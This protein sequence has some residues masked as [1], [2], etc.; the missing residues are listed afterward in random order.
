MARWQPQGNNDA[1]AS[2]LQPRYRRLLSVGALLDES[3]QLFRQHWITLALFGLAALVPSWLVLLILYTGGF[4]QRVLLGSLD[5][6]ASFPIAAL[7]MVMGLGLLSGL[8]TVLWTAASTAAANAF[9]HGRRPSVVG[10]YVHALKRFPA[11]LGATVVYVLIAL[12]LTIA[13]GVLFV[14]TGLGTI[15]TL[16]AVVGLIYWWRQRAGR[17]PWLKWLIILTAPFGLVTYYSLRWALWL[18]ALVIE[19]EGP[20]GSL[21][22]SHRLTEHE[23]FRVFS[24]LSLV[25]VIVLV[26]VSVPVTIVDI[27]FGVFARPGNTAYQEALQV[28][29]STV[30][31]LCQVLFS[32]IATI[33]YLLLFV[34]LR[35]R[36]YGTDLGERIDSLEMSF[37][38]P[39][40]GS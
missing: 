8:F 32:G 30:S 22:R 25:S 18:P 15:G 34:D 11:L 37:A 29:N 27:L 16:I 5:T 1:P 2:S 21:R 26:L 24:V 40:V 13:S 20:I 12:G 31:S 14:I 4:Q 39:D 36:R 6:D 7:A 17:R 19:Q 23:W 10:I 35:N 9:I 3:I 33:T 38:V 28:I